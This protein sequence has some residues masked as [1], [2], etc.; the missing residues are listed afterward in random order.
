VPAAY[1]AQLFAA[2]YR[3]EGRTRVVA[4]GEGGGGRSSAQRRAG[5]RPEGGGQVAARSQVANGLGA[6][7]AAR[8]PGFAAPT[9]GPARC[10]PLRER[11]RVE[12][13]QGRPAGPRVPRLLPPAP[14]PLPAQSPVP[15][16]TSAQGVGAAR[17]EPQRARL[18]APRSGVAKA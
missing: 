17:G 13:D 15:D 5:W 9:P 18:M 16:V 3:R 2:G 4:P 12:G 6:A 14:L 11:P 1:G 8:S 7:R 10:W